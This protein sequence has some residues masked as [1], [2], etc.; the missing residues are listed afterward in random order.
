M[1]EANERKHAKYAD[2]VEECHRWEWHARYVPIE[3]GCRG[4]AAR[5]L[6]KA[7]SLLGSTGAHQRKAIKTTTEAA[8]KASRWLWIAKGTQGDANFR[9]GQQ[10]PASGM[11]RPF[12]QVV[13][14][15]VK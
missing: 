11:V 13:N 1:E 8:E 12:S 9:V 14:S 6:C 4:F 10:I 3:V 15:R 2:L 5:S 7:Y